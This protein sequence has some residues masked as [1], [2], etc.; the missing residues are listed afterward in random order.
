M[1]VPSLRAAVPGAGGAAALLAAVLLLW[2]CGEEE[3]PADRGADTGTR[4][5]VEVRPEGPDGPVE[6]RTVTDPP[7]GIT[8]SDFEPV[9]G[10]VACTEI[11]GGPATATVR[12][13]LAGEPIDAQFS[14]TDGC[15]MARWDAVEPLL[16]KVPGVRPPGP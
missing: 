5:E 10:D 7:P 2:A 16:G 1:V 8:P 9:P 4:L 15:Q 6:R 12:G 3:R 11:Y 13:T 14:R